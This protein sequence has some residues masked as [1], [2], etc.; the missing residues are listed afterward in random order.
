MP[1]FRTLAVIAMLIAPWGSAAAS[2]PPNPDDGEQA[3]L[4]AMQNTNTW[5]HPDQYGEFT[6]MQAY[7]AGQYRTAFNDFKLGARYADKVSQLCIGLMYLSGQG[8]DKDPAT[9]YAWISLAAERGYPEFVA[10]RDKLG[11]QLTPAERSSA[12]ASMKSLT[13][14]Y[15]DAAAKPRMASYMRS[16]MQIASPTGKPPIGVYTE[17]GGTAS[18]TSDCG[19]AGGHGD[20]SF[21]ARWRWD[22]KQYFAA[23]D[24]QWLAPAKGTVTVEP[25]QPVASPDSVKKPGS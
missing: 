2:T 9:A 21:Y 20:C 3:L 6:G 12:E 24:A 10:T 5:G 14:E 19:P 1:S 11:K 25:L 22:P 13:A 16:T 18:G 23:R 7:A 17:L 15:G 8:L 4:T